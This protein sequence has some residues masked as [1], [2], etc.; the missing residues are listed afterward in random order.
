MCTS[1]TETDSA[2]SH[3]SHAHVV[4]VPILISRFGEGERSVVTG[5]IAGQA[6]QHLHMHSYG[7]IIIGTT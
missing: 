4:G 5:Q 2:M 7:V 3:H 1:R 6:N